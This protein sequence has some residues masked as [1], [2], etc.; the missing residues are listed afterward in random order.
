MQKKRH[1]RSD[2]P[3]KRALF[4]RC[5]PRCNLLIYSGLYNYYLTYLDLIYDDENKLNYSSKIVHLFF[6]FFLISLLLSM[7]D[8]FFKVPSSV[9]ADNSQNFSKD[10]IDLLSSPTTAYGELESR[11]GIF[12]RSN[13]AFLTK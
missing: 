9:S 13:Q 3:H 12:T 10:F 4:Q 11:D 1:R 5:N 2:S 8:F 7:L 6:I